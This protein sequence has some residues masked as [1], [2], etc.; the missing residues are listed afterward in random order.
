MASHFWA[1]VPVS[2]FAL[3]LR[4]GPWMRRVSGAQTWSALRP[5]GRATV[6]QVAGGGLDQGRARTGPATCDEWGRP[7][8][9]ARDHPVATVKVFSID[10]PHADNWVASNRLQGVSCA[11]TTGGRHMPCSISVFLGAG[12]HPRVDRLSADRVALGV[13]RIVHRSH[14]ATC[15]HAQA[16]R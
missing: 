8:P 14:C 7:F 10:E 3:L 12:V 2:V 13:G 5:R 9:V 11:S 1:L 4:E 6:N 16:V 15:L